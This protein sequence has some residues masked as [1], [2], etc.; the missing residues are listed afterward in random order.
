[1][2][3]IKIKIHQK[4]KEWESPV[5][6]AILNTTPDS[7]YS[8]SRL[9]AKDQIHKR[10]DDVV[11]Q[12]A[13]I[14]DIGG[15]STRPGAETI[16]EKQEWERIRPA[17][18]YISKKYPEF[19]VS[20]D[21]FRPQIALKSFE[22]FGV[23]IINDISGGQLDPEMLKTVGQ[24]GMAY[25]GMHMRCNPETMNQLTDY[26]DLMFDLCRY[27]GNLHQQCKD[28]GIAD[29][30]L[31]PGIGF[32]KNIDQNYTILNNLEMLKMLG[33]P[34][35]IGVSR[36]SLIYKFLDTS[37]EDSLIGTTVLNTLAVLKG[38]GIL[39]VHDVKEASQTI[40]LIQK[41]LN[42]K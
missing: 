38:A 17:L 4:I 21:T 5:I 36:K 30:I 10:I 7:F 9:T 19:P 26:N 41:T 28:V 23:D 20:V 31:D 15:M 12:G 1:M 6:M 39:R 35:L 42:S 8:Q 40:K 27:F 18:E 34:I 33:F 14:L 22:L 2:Q 25:V 16:D 11:E 13:N 32:S 37:P 29:F 24:A 3:N